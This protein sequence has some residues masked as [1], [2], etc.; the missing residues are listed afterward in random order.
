MN[1]EQ[2]E[3]KYELKLIK[4]ILKKE[5]PWIKQVSLSDKQISPRSILLD[6]KIDP[7]IFGETFDVDYHPEFN[8][9]LENMPK[10]TNFHL[11]FDIS[12]KDEK[13]LIEEIK[14]VIEKIRKSEMIPKELKLPEKIFFEIG[15]SV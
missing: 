4:S 3:N 14:F 7:V 11:L 12:W 8:I 5:Y 1:R 15:V 13:E 6:I 9:N 2:I 10:T